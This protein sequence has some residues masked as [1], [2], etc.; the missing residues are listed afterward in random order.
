M[1]E[2]IF[3]SRGLLEALG[4]EREGYRRS[5]EGLRWWLTAVF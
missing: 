2:F 5:M 4:K 3:P 1:I